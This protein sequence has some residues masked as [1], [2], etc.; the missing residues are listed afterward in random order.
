VTATMDAGP[1]LSVQDLA[2]EFRTPDGVVNAVNGV[3]FDLWPGETLAVVGE[4]GSGKSVTAMSILGL[5]PQPPG[6]TARGQIL[7]EGRDLL[8]MPRSEL[9]RIRGSEIAMVFQDPMTSLNPVLKVGFQIAETI[10]EHARVAL[11]Q[12]RRLVVGLLKDVRVPSPED[13]FHQYPH[14]FSGGMR[15][16]ALIAM[17]IANNPRVIIADEPTTALDVT[18]QAQ[19]FETLKAAQ[20]RTRAAMILITHD[21]GLVAELADRVMVMYAGRVVETADVRSIFRDPR[22]PYTQGLLRSLPSVD[23]RRDR[24]T[25]IPGSPPSLIA[26]PPGCPFQ[27]RCD[28]AAGRPICVDERPALTPSGEG[29]RAACHFAT[30]A[31]PASQGTSVA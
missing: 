20:A 22:H 28:R 23:R 25:P 11:S 21:L 2:V 4:S 16:R 14:Q 9:R 24:L 12:A 15:Q 6:R 30:E 18:I 13:R 27:P 3:S 10:M 1:V 17:A 7:F 8:A 26:L 5:V 31:N 29:R 19:I